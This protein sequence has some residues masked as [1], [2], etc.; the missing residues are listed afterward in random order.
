MNRSRSP[1]HP[2]RDQQLEVRRELV[3]AGPRPLRGTLRVPGDKSLSHRALLLAAVAEGRSTI[4]G[5]GGGADV[6]RSRGLIESLGARIRERGDEVRISGGGWD[7]LREPAEVIDC[8]NSGTTLRVGLGLVAGRPF[9]SVLGGDDSLSRRPM[10]RVVEPL[11][12]MG[13]TI[14]GREEGQF[15]PLAVRGGEL[16]GTVHD[17]TVASAQVKTAL[18]LAGLQAS[19]ETTIVSPVRSRDH[20]ERMLGALDVPIEDEGET[21]RVRA[22][23]LPAFEFDVPGDPS[24]AAFF[25]VAALV[26]PGSELTIERVSLN[27]TRVAFLDVLARM[28][29][30]IETEQTGESLGEPFG[31]IRVASSPLSGT[32]IEGDEVPLVIDEIPVLAV[33]AAFAEGITE[34]R[35]AA[36]LAVKETN[37]IGAVEQELSQ[38]GVDVEARRDGLVIQG[39]RPEANRFKSH[40]DHRVAMAMAVAANACAGESQILGWRA[41][42]V[43]YPGFDGD[44]SRATQPSG[45][46]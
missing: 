29:A 24:S 15:A 7:T 2:E 43:S 9:H 33:A 28:G 17:L 20:T 11:R 5:L 3:L 39:G 12:A 34:V 23:S 25:V 40:G 44:L 45:V 4:R 21:V 30:S 37:R 42:E 35:D 38:L 27:P 18:L 36:E 32:V 31:V 22:A 26:T 41:V 10:L 1:E 16:A 6:A 19:G 14:D 13:A 8:G 46:A